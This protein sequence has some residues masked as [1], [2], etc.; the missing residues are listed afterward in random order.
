[1]RKI[2]PKLPDGGREKRIDEL[3]VLHLYGFIYLTYLNIRC[4]VKAHPEQLN[5]RLMRPQIKDRQ[6]IVFHNALA[7]RK[8]IA[9]ANVFEIFAGN[10]AEGAG[11][12]D[13]ELAIAL[14]LVVIHLHGLV[15]V[16]ERHVNLDEKYVA[17]VVRIRVEHSND[18]ELMASKVQILI[19]C[20]D[21]ICVEVEEGNG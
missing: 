20:G 14:H 13:A 6:V 12:D 11:D 15:D 7:L 1:M 10:L 17:L 4:G 9:D 8:G 18:L 19:D 21:I 5:L 16:T 3:F 2:R